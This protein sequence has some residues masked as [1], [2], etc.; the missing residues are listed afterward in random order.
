MKNINII[1]LSNKREEH[2]KKYRID[3]ESI[4]ECKEKIRPKGNIEELSKELHLLISSKNF[5]EEESFERMTELIIKGAN[6]DYKDEKKGD[7]PLLICCRKGYKGTFILLIRFG[8][9]INNKN[10]YG[11]TA[12]MA[13]AR[14]GYDELL[15]LLIEKG[16]DI[17]ERCID[18]DNA[19]DSAKI[20]NELDCV[21]LLEE[22]SCITSSYD[23]QI[24]T[25]EEKT[26][27]AK[28]MSIIDKALIDLDKVVDKYQLKS[29]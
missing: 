14:H 17:D 18:S 25:L 22:S 10:N 2:L 27:H 8:A 11:T 21:K 23:Y 12:T 6:V 3:D 1:E 20:H 15:K 29:K 7:F 13:A 24:E 26:T 28:V 19:L 4:K 9:N 16:A 5:N